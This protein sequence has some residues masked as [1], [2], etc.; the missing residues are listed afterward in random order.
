MRNLLILMVA[1]TL[2]GISAA[3]PSAGQDYNPKAE[4]QALKARQKL[5]RQA[6]KVKEKAAKLAWKNSQVPKSV[7]LQM[8]HQIQR[9][10]RALL[11]RQKNERQQ[12]EDRQ[13]IARESRRIYSQ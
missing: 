10:R 5:E 11:E 8:K 6:F 4:R 3:R 9:E 13:R 1:A 12:M 2:L 7:R